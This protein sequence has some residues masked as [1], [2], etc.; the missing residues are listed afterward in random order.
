MVPQRV[1][2]P[3]GRPALQGQ[4]FEV[5]A[6]RVVEA[7]PDRI[8]AL[9]SQFD[10]DIEGAV[11]DVGIVAGPA[12]HAVGAGA[13]V[14][15]VLAQ[16][17][18]QDVVADIAVQAVIAVAAVQGVGGVGGLDDVVAGVARAVQRALHQDQQLDLGHQHVRN[19][20]LHGVVAAQ[21]V[22]DGL[23]GPV[24][25]IEDVVAITAGHR[26]DARAAVQPVRPLAAVEDVGALLAKQQIGAVHS[27]EGVDAGR[28]GQGVGRGV[29]VARGFAADPEGQVLDLGLQGVVGQDAVDRIGPAGR[30]FD[31]QVAVGIDLIG[32][33]ARPADHPVSAGQAVQLVSPGAAVQHVDA[34]RADQVVDALQPDEGTGVRGRAAE[35]IIAGSGDD[36]LEADGP[37]RDPAVVIHHLILEAARRRRRQDPDLAADDRDGAADAVADP[38]DGQGVAVGVA[39]IGGQGAEGHGHRHAARHRQGIAPRRWHGLGLDAAVADQGRDLGRRDAQDADDR[40]V[41]HAREGQGDAAAVLGHVQVGQRQAEP[42]EEQLVRRRIEAVD[43]VRAVAQGE[44]EPVG[45]SGLSVQGIVALPAIER[46]PAGLAVEHVVPAAAEQLVVQSA[47]REH[48]GAGGAGDHIVAGPADGVLD[49]DQGVDAVPGRRAG[50]QVDGLERQGAGG[51]IGVRPV[52]AVD[53][54]VA[55]RA[56]VEHLAAARAEGV[57]AALA[58]DRIIVVAAAEDVAAAAARNLVVAAP[59]LDRIDAVA[60]IIRPADQDLAPSAARQGVGVGAAIDGDHESQ[61]RQGKLLDG[62]G[63]VAR[64]AACQLHRLAAQD[65][66]VALVAVDEVDRVREPGLQVV[67]AVEDVVAAP[68]VDHVAAAAAING[69]ARVAAGDVVA[70]EPAREIV[71]RLDADQ[72]RPVA[73]DVIAAGVFVHEGVAAGAAD[74]GGVE[75]IAAIDGRI[76]V[77]ASQN[78]IA[79][80][81]EQQV[82]SAQARDVVVPAAAL[83]VVGDL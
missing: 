55:I 17:A 27:V 78:V 32:V 79:V 21:E 59:A 60:Q 80:L 23:V 49:A 39:V 7:G 28:A 36:G 72:H 63:V 74:L 70:E 44:M 76:L 46:V 56:E 2:R 69:V 54:V 42:G 45:L 67:Q 18:D 29:A 10:D 1:A 15:G 40:S 66:V 31:G 37:G 64:S 26:I 35:V 5:V 20:G 81:S 30:Q 25:D 82:Q 62:D 48:I 9:V 41:R 33:I 83:Q 38:Q 19:R 8:D 61:R 71:D 12:G 77:V 73:A 11:D 3:L 13:A 75:T 52:A 16:A 68:A 43:G 50:G 34:G 53:Q 22:F 6:Q 65:R 14:Q 4:V 58:I 24:V 57:I 51:V 47:A